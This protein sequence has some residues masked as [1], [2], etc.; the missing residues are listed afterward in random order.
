MSCGFR[1][2]EHCGE[3]RVSLEHS[4]TGP[5]C[6]VPFTIVKGQMTVGCVEYLKDI[7]NVLKHNRVCLT[8]DELQTKLL[9]G[10]NVGLHVA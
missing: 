2:G 10:W 8:V 4:S 1:H 6:A 5:L 7:F 3:A 9:I